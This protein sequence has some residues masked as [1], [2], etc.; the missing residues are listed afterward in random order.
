M[1][2]CQFTQLRAFRI[3]LSSWFAIF[4]ELVIPKSLR[5]VERHVDPAC[6]HIVG[7]RMAHSDCLP[8]T[9]GFEFVGLIR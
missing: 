6:R 8:I 5:H 7:F 2:L 4:F 3:T 1:R 9:P